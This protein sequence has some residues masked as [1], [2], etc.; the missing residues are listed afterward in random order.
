MLFL[1]SIPYSFSTQTVKSVQA[2]RPHQHGRQWKT[3]NRRPNCSFF[4]FS[5]VSIPVA[6][7]WGKEMK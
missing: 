6:Q 7:Y 5:C 1:R 3:G 2:V 4:F